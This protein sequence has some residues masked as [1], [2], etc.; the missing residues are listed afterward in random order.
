MTSETV[1]H[2]PVT[3]HRARASAQP[4]GDLDDSPEP[5]SGACR[6]GRVPRPVRVHQ[7][8]EADLTPLFGLKHLRTIKAGERALIDVRQVNRFDL[9]YLELPS[10]DWTTLIDA[11]ELPKNLLALGISD[12]YRFSQAEKRALLDR[13]RVAYGLPIPE[14]WTL[15]G[16]VPPAA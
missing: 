11:G 10:A 9:E 5:H 15:S 4:L 14:G 16:T 2:D 3:W 7:D 8:R 1:W 6:A 13:L 12:A